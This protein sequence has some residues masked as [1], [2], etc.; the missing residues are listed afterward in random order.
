MREIAAGYEASGQSRGAYAAAQGV[1]VAALDYHRRRGR[2]NGSKLVEIDWQAGSAAA[3]P[4]GPEIGI[5]LRNGRRIE[6]GWP[7]LEGMGETGS[8]L[9]RLAGWLERA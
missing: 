4:G 8:R 2:Q 9:I 6:I 1:T 5:V 7:A 3:R